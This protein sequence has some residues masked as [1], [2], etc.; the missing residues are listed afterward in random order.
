[1]YYGTFKHIYTPIETLMYKK[2]TMFLKYLPSDNIPRYYV[3]YVM[4]IPFSLFTCKKTYHIAM[5]DHRL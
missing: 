5:G 2:Q 4:K 1:M 3:F